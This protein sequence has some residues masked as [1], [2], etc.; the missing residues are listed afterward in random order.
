MRFV[1]WA[2][3]IMGAAWAGCGTTKWT[4]T[5]RTATEQLLI[6]DAMER[7]VSQVDLRALAG[8]QVFL[9]DS[10]VRQATDTAYLV[11]SVRQHILASGG[12]LKEKREEAEYV[13]ELRAGAVGTDRHD[14]LFGVPQTQVPTLIPIGG[15][16]GATIP[17]IPLVKR[18]EQ[19][20]VAKIAVFAYNRQ[21]GRPIWQSGVVPAESKAK[22]IWVFGAGP[23]QRGTIYEGTKFAGDRFN[24]PLL[25]PGE[26]VDS[27]EV[28]VAREAYFTEP[29]RELARQP[30]Q[31]LSKDAATP[32]KPPN[33]PAPA[34]TS[35]G[36]V[37]TSHNGPSG[38]P[39]KARP[40]A[41]SDSPLAASAAPPSQATAGQSA[42]AP[43]PASPAPSPANV[44]SPSSEP[45]PLPNGAEPPPLSPG[46]A[47]PWPGASGSGN[48]YHLLPPYVPADPP[49]Y[50]AV[51]PLPYYRR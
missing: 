21:T 3:L 1:V 47:S 16:S 13:V 27:R 18:T 32:A 15:A 5:A 46:P 33:D 17:E 38:E 26:D 22:A 39:E 19:R 48:V 12:I 50:P 11:S 34:P 29:R 42:G 43:K 28:S 30:Q 36:V 25:A 41:A 44:A 49:T 37:Q 6:A 24:I 51:D 20:A 14:V 10:P 8:K 31:P 35:S 2:I 9:D 7:A 40:A 23:F 45:G 4:D